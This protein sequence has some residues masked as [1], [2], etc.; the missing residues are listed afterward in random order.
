MINLRRT[1]D[2]K[3]PGRGRQRINPRESQGVRHDRTENTGNRSQL[4]VTPWFASRRR[5]RSA[6]SLETAR[7]LRESLEI[8][9]LQVSHWVRFRPQSRCPRP[10][11]RS[12]GEAF[13][14]SDDAGI[15]PAWM[16]DPARRRLP[17]QCVPR[18]S[19]DTAHGS[20]WLKPGGPVRPVRSAPGPASHVVH[21]QPPGRIPDW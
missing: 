5:W 4:P 14:S 6:R 7:R 1:S 16:S 9:V 12:G 18:S 20:W 11:P 19:G 13:V 8:V 17:V 10:E 21:I 3:Q 15:G 2:E